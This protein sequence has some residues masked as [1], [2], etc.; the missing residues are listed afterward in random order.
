MAQIPDHWD[1]AEESEVY[2]PPEE[3]TGT[4]GESSDDGKATSQTGKSNS[5]DKKR[6]RL[7]LI[8]FA[9][10]RPDKE[11]PYLVKCDGSQRRHRHSGK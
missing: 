5:G 7:G 1:S 6:P 10:I 8:S 4:N 2:E 11:P 9:D 3:I